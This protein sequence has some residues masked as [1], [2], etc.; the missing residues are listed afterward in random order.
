MDAS[1]RRLPTIALILSSA[2]LAV[3]GCSGSSTP[4]AN[5]KSVEGWS[6]A[7]AGTT[8]N[9]IAEATANSATHRGPAARLHEEDRHQ[10]P[11]SSRRPTTAWCRRRCWTSPPRREPTTW[12][13][14]PTSTSAASPR[15]STSSRVD[16]C[17]AKPRRDV[18]PGTTT[19][20]HPPRLCGRPPRSGRTS[21]LRRAVQQRGD[22]DVLPQGPV[23]ESPSSRTRSRPSTAT[24]SRRPRHG[25]STATSPSSSPGPRVMTWPV[26]RRAE[27]LYG[28]DDGRQAPRVDRPGVDELQLELRRGH[29]R[30]LPASRR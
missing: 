18:A 14:S 12:S 17:V 27:P 7:H 9:V 2:S 19:D 23:G 26:S 21:Y 24:P 15:R 11:D 25:T 20:G 1:R 30:L 29:L 8:L 4:D 10:R 22:D 5:A 28:V 6:Q 16:D 3:A 13:R